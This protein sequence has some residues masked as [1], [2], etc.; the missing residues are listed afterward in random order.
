MS[1]RFG[2]RLYEIFFK[3]YT[4]KVWGI[5]C[6]E[7][8]A[9]WAAQRIKNLSLS[10]ALRNALFNEQRAKDGEIITTLIDAVPLPAAR[11]RA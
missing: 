6:T 3:T 7:I 1:N 10:E 4:E 8:S 5:P 9:E 11:A 2:Q